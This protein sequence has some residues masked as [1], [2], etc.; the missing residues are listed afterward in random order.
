M[1]PKLKLCWITAL[2]LIAFTSRAQYQSIDRHAQK[3]PS[4]LSKDLPALAEY[5]AAPAETEAERARAFFTWVVDYLR[6]DDAAARRGKRINQSIRDILQRRRGLCMDYARLF[7]A[8]CGYGGLRCAIVDG[9][10]RTKLDSRELPPEANHSWNAVYADGRWLLVDATWA[11]SADE[12]TT[13]FET[14][15]FDTPPALFVLN[16]LPQQPMWQLLPCPVSAEQFT[17]SVSQVQ[18]YLSRADSCMAYADSIR[19]QLRLPSA[20]QQLRKMRQAYDFHPSVDNQEQL[21]HAML[22]YA[23]HLDEQAEALA[24]ADST[25]ALMPLQQ[26]AIRMAREAAEWVELQDWQQQLL[27]RLHINHAIALYQA[28]EVTDE[29]MLTKALQYTEEGLQWLEKLPEGHYYRSY[30]ERQCRQLL[31][32]LHYWLD[33]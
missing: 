22:D 27:A 16:H 18:A 25:T 2:L 32:Q 4:E 24:L 33:K 21:A 3:A 17:S 20:E 23:V 11:S 5:L 14:S 9:Y 10:V 19:H 13:R 12:L 15:Y 6:Y 7:K 8:L 26:R 29:Q 31:E 1:R 28:A 30:A